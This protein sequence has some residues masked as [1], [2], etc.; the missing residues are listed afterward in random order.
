MGLGAGIYREREVGERESGR[1]WERPAAAI[2]GVGGFSIIGEG[3]E[4]E[5]KG[6]GRRYLAWGWDGTWGR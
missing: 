5:R 1:E 4:G 3:V 6:R 2:N